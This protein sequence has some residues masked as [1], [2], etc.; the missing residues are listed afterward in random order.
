MLFEQRHGVPALEEHPTFF[1]APACLQ[2]DR[3]SFNA[4]P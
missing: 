4:V 1:G 3:V 2:H